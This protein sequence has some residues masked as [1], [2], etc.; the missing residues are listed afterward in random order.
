[1]AERFSLPGREY[2]FRETLIAP[3]Y[4]ADP[5]E[6]TRS[7]KKLFEKYFTD[8]W[9]VPN[10]LTMLRLVLIPVFVVLYINGQTKW[11]LAVFIIASLTDLLDGRIARKYNLITNFGKLMDPLADKLMVCTALICQGIYGVIPWA[12]II[13]VLAKEVLMVVGAWVM[14][15]NDVVVHSNMLGK[16]AMCSF[17]AALVLSFFHDE[18]LAL[19]FPWDVIILWLSIA[20][21]LAAFVDYLLAGIKVLKEKKQ[22]A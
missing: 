20:L 16:V 17:V 1:M 13:I 7:V 14:L 12:A 21:T 11:A 22:A 3:Y 5:A 19:G 9:N 18:F 4:A 15:K 10:V 8:I 6:R 2:F